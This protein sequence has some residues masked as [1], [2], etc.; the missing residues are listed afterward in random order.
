MRRT[1]LVDR[2]GPRSLEAASASARW[3]STPRQIQAQPQ[4][5]GKQTPTKQYTSTLPQAKEPNK[6]TTQKN[7]SSSEFLDKHRIEQLNT[8]APLN[9]M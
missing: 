8:L 3:A 1:L 5:A 7:H 9:I 2:G 6:S 4:I